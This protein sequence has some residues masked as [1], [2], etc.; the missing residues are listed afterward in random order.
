M[1]GRQEGFEERRKGMRGGIHGRKTRKE[2]MEGR[3]GRK[4]RKKGRKEG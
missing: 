4:T 1:A 2:V 3:Q